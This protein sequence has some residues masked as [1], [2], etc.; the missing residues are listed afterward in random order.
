MGSFIQDEKSVSSLIDAI[1][2]ET[3]KDAEERELEIKL[4]RLKMSRLAKHRRSELS[5]T[6]A[7]LLRMDAEAYNH[8]TYSK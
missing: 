3:T 1:N 5:E 8:I 2:V 7:E 6:E 4:L